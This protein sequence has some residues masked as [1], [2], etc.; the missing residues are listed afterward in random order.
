MSVNYNNKVFKSV[1][2]SSNAEVSG[3][4]L[5]HYHQEG[6]VVWAEYS[7]GVIIKGHLIAKLG[8]AGE[9]NMRYHHIN[10]DLEIMTGTCQSRPEALPDG[11]LRL[12]EQWQWTSGD[13]SEGTSLVEE[14]VAN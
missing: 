7:G 12:H 2:S 13:H 5:F 4:T 8:A 14:V 9:L 10:S 3:E 1:S 6:Q 11:R